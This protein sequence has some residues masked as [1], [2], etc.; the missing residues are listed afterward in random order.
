MSNIVD[1]IGLIVQKVRDTYNTADST[2]ITADS[3]TITADGSGGQPYYLYGHRIEIANRLL[4]KDKDIYFKDQKYPLIA[5]RM[6]IPEQVDGDVIHYTLNIAILAKTEK[7]YHSEERYEKV[8]VPILLPLYEEF[9][10]RLRYAGIFMWTGNLKNPPH[11]KIDR[12]FWGIT[13][14]E[15]NTKYIFNDPLDGIEIVDLKLTKRAGLCT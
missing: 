11:T 14:S 2:L 5:L 9:M 1:D 3:T 7:N 12:L 6:D 8:V 13:S 15:G 4:E 10:K